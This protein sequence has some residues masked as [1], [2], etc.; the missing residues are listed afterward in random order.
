MDQT[1]HTIAQALR[2]LAAHDHRAFRW[3][4]DKYY[5]AVATVGHKYLQDAALTQDFVQELFSSIW[6]RRAQFAGVDNFEA[7]FFT[8]SRNLAV[9]YIKRKASQALTHETY[10]HVKPGAENSMTQSVFVPHKSPSFHS[11]EIVAL[12]GSTPSGNTLS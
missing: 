11:K 8:L 10:T 6:T 1:Y 3:I 7:Y 4:Y 9:Q 5:Y 12:L 2:G